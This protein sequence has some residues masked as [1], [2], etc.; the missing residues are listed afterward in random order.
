MCSRP[1]PVR[2]L[3]L[4]AS[5]SLSRVSDCE[6]PAISAHSRRRCAGAAT[7]KAAR[8]SSRPIPTDPSKLVGFDVEIAELIA[9]ELGRAPQFVQVAFTSLDQSAARGDFD[10]GLSGIEDIAGA[11]RGAGRQRSV[12]RVPRSADR[13]RRPIATAFAR[14]PICAAAASPRSA[15]RSPTTSCS[16]AER[17]HGIIAGVLRR[18]RASVH[19]ICCSAASTRC[20]ST[21]CSPSARCA[22]TPGLFTQPDGRRRPATTSSSLAPGEHGA[23]RPR[24][25]RSCARRCATAGSKRSSASGTS[26]TTT[27]RGSTRSVLAGEPIA[28]APAPSVGARRVARCE[29]HA[30]RYLPA[31]LR[32]AGITLVLSCLAMALAVALGVADRERP[33]LRRSRSRAAL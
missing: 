8:R 14:S 9:R 20:C 22:A 13:A 7:P 16:R 18:R 1:A 11:P 25:T 10:I 3:A 24:R 4:A 19:A 21:T 29:A 33:R 6:L 30:A 23:A 31:L 5:R 17:E 26:G 27:S 12:L 2:S 32:A 15:A 28:R